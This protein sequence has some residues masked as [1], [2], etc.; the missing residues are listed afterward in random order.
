MTA[1]ELKIAKMVLPYAIEQQMRMR[2]A[3]GKF[4]HYTSAEAGL[5]ILRGNSILL[6]NS[7]LMNDFSEVAYGMDCLS[8]AYDGTIGER[9][10]AVMRAVQPDLPE[11]FEASY[12]T[13]IVDI[14]QETYLLSISEHG[15]E[16]EDRFGRLSMWRAYAA[17][18]GIAFVF[19]NTPFL[20]DTNAL[21]AFTSPVMYATP[22][23]FEI[24]VESIVTGLEASLDLLK[25]FGGQWLHDT[26]LMAFVFAIQ[27]TKHPSFQEEREWRVIYSPTT[28][29]KAGQLTSQ[30]AERV[31][32]EIMC[33]NSVPQRVFRIPFKD[34][35]DEGFIGATVPAMLDR[36]LIGP[37]LDAYAIAQ[38]FIAELSAL[39]VERAP[40]KVIITGIPLRQ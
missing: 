13:A 26:L 34:Y 35:P 9:L 30:Q 4:V 16:W 28:L 5:L 18:N 39:G 32:T 14:R 3:G 36:V 17:R 29:F 6:R 25:Q 7:T 27:S 10:K 2:A 15:N 20:A 21:Q 11:I 38:A 31:P 40:E 23:T 24:H 37:S 33:L 22:E 1:D 19:N 12:N 8:S